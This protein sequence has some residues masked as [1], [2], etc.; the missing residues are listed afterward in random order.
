MKHILGVLVHNHAGVLSKVSGLFARRGYNIDSLA[1][2]TTRDPDVSRITIMTTG[3][4][5][6]LEQILKQLNKLIDVVKVTDVSN[7]SVKRE[8]V[9]IKVK[10]PAAGRGEI[11]E[12]ANIFRA[13]IVDVSVDMMTIEATGPEEKINAL[14][15]MLRPYGIL[16]L[17]RT[18]TIAIQRGATTLGGN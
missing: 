1:V 3:D 16:E 5:G 9:L 11:I 12:V 18:G 13:N 17:V 15:K 7:D 10:A 6:T 14:I 4:E 8:L 2:G